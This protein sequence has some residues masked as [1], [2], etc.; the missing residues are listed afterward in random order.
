M[1]VHNEFTAEVWILHSSFVPHSMCALWIWVEKLHKTTENVCASSWK[2][3]RIPW[4]KQS[5]SR[6]T[7]R[8][9]AS[10]L[11][12]EWL[13]ALHIFS[14]RVLY[15]VR[16]ILQCEMLIESQQCSPFLRLRM[17]VRSRLK[18][19]LSMPCQVNH[20]CLL[21]NTYHMK[22]PLWRK[23]L[24]IRRK[25]SDEAIAHPYTFLTK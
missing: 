24:K 10:V 13:S 5:N 7:V 6:L 17:S 22:T 14:V 21:P 8:K 15:K 4:Q 16:C 3:C 25:K 20:I 9:I 2:E 11:L 19:F 18:S 1:S 23:F 12:L